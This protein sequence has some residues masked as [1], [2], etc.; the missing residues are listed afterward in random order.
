MRA[1]SR[2][3]ASHRCNM[4]TNSL[5]VSSFSPNFKRYN[6]AE[7][8]A[9]SYKAIAFNLDMPVQFWKCLKI[10]IVVISSM[11]FRPELPLKCSA[12][13]VNYMNFYNC[14]S[15]HCLGPTVSFRIHCV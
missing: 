10:L 12:V 1:A 8:L 2:N 5:S 11:I 7:A 14:S 3:I 13:N 4:D 9:S 6:S 15:D